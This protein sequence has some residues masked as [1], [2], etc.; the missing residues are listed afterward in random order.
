[1]I[2]ATFKL[3]GDNH[4]LLWLITKKRGDSISRE[5]AG[6]ALQDKFG[7]LEPWAC[8]IEDLRMLET[9]EEKKEAFANI[10]SEHKLHI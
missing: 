2:C 9:E 6:S 1:M 7:T 3:R 5:D 10:D 8:D 4:A